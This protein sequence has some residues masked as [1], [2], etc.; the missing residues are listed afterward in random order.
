MPFKETKEGQTHYQNDGC[1]EKEHNCSCTERGDIEELPDM[2]K[3]I[4]TP[5]PKK[6]KRKKILKDFAESVLY[7][8]ARGH[9]HTDL[10][11]DRWLDLITAPQ[12]KREERKMKKC[13][14]CIV[15]TLGRCISCERK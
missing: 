2:K 13:K 12:D 14:R 9:E 10:E 6:E 3:E 11:L 5:Q 7:N 15:G 1:G 4:K 8:D